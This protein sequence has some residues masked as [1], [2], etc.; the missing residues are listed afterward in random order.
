[1]ELK[2]FLLLLAV[3]QLPSAFADELHYALGD[4]ID[5]A[6]MVADQDGSN[7]SLQTLLAEETSK[8]NVLFIFGG[9][10]LGSGSPGHLWCPDSYEDTYILRTLYGKYAQQNVNFIA[11]AVPPAYHSQMLGKPA[12]VFLDESVG[13]KALLD[14]NSAFISSTLAAQ[15]D[16]ILPLQPYFDLRIGLMMNRSEGLLPGTAWG[17]LEAWHGAFRKEGETQFYG[18]PSF[19]LL[20][21]SGEVLGEPFR[22]NVYHPHGSA[23]NIAYTY[24][25]IDAA[26]SALVQE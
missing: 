19:W 23:V 24:S 13:S 7:V 25:D 10:D 9:G 17:E 14:A 1:M 2:K 21:D 8:V 6:V 20:S 16:G 11:V 4:V 5:A 26:I 12:R 15:T 3:I 18:V 22:G